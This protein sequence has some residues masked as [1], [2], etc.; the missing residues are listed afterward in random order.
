MSDQFAAL[1]ASTVPVETVDD[2]LMRAVERV[3]SELA[4][5]TPDVSVSVRFMLSAPHEAPLSHEVEWGV[6]VG[7]E[8]GRAG[9]FED[10]LAKVKSIYAS[11]IEGIVQGLH[12]SLRRLDLGIDADQVVAQ[13][14]RR[15]KQEP[16][17]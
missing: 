6:Q 7:N 15:L 14:V 5:G 11:R 13:A 8:F 1:V 17:R 9:T 16:G 3:R 12:A 2:V 10:A 4:L